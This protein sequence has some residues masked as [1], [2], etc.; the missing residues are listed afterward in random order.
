MSDALSSH[1]SYLC[2]YILSYNCVPV[3]FNIGVM[4]PVLKKTI[5]NLIV[6]ANYRRIFVYSIFSNLFELIV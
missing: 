6:A 2:S 4:V 1:L 5:L 3:V